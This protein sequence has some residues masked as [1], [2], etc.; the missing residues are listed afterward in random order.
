VTCCKARTRYAFGGFRGLVWCLWLHRPNSTDM[1]IPCF[2]QA[3]MKQT[4]AKQHS[5]SLQWMTYSENGQ[6][7]AKGAHREGP[8]YT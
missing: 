5:G 4:H 8:Q 3:H 6:Y 1:K 7:L 2:V